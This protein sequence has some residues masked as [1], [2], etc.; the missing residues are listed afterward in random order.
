[1][2]QGSFSVEVHILKHNILELILLKFHLRLTV[3]FFFL[4]F[5]T[6]KYFKFAIFCL[7]NIYGVSFFLQSTKTFFLDLRE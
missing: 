2:D 6:G 3:M 7:E 4:F 1:M 5:V